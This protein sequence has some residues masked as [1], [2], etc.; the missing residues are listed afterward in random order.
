MTLKSSIY[1]ASVIEEH[2]LKYCRYEYDEQ[3]NV[4]YGGI[5][6]QE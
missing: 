2:K 6:T 4:A 5:N 1:V 3:S